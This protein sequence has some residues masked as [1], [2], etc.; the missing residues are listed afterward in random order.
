[1]PSNP[2]GLDLLISAQKA[3]V[4]PSMSEQE[5]RVCRRCRIKVEAGF[6]LQ[7]CYC[8]RRSVA[9][10]IPVRTGVEVLTVQQPRRDENAQVSVARGHDR[11]SSSRTRGLATRGE[12]LEIGLG[13]RSRTLSLSIRAI[14]KLLFPSNTLALNEAVISGRDCKSENANAIR[15]VALFQGRLATFLFLFIP[16][17][18]SNPI[19]FVPCKDVAIFPGGREGTSAVTV[20]PAVKVKGRLYFLLLR[21]DSR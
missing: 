20:T 3:R 12:S 19:T 2:V 21:I 11:R 9:N 18:S 1:M 14:V 15:R 13:E 10:G 17:E 16:V 6:V 4:Q 5:Q 7:L 8:S